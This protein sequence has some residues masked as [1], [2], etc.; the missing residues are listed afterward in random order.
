[1]ED[2]KQEEFEAM[3]QNLNPAEDLQLP[4]YSYDPAD[5]EVAE[6][7][8]YDEA[9]N[10]S[11]ISHPPS[12]R[13]RANNQSRM[14]VGSCSTATSRGPSPY[15]GD[16]GYE[17]LSSNDTEPSLPTSAQTVPSNAAYAG[18]FGFEISFG[19]QMKETKSTTWTYSPA[20]RKLF[21]RMA[22]TCPIRFQT[23]CS[24]SSFQLEESS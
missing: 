18:K 20:I 23:A 11:Y 10:S 1:M 19:Q 22:T 14:S 13:S 24:M 3:W 6:L 4:G 16:P 9:S 21:V 5:T 12:H 15:L 2:M 7:A 17:S 8:G